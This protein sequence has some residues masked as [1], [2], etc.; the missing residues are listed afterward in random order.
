METQHSIQDGARV[1]G[2]RRALIVGLGISGMAAALRLR[3]IGWT[4]VIVERSAARRSGG[5]FIALFRAGLA[6]AG[7]LGILDRLTDLSTHGN[8]VDTDRV[9]RRWPGLS[10]DVFPGPP[11][12]MRRGDLEAAA[13]AALAADVEIRYGAEPVGIDQDAAGVDVTLADASSGDR[14]TERFD[15]VVG[16]DGLR[17]TV[18]RLVFG[19]DE[20]HLRRLGHM[21]LAY[22]LPAAL[23]GFSDRD[24]VLL[25]EPGRAMWSF[26][27]RGHPPTAL[28][29]YHTD[30][31]DAEFAGPIPDRVRQVFGPQP[32]GPVLGAA[33]DALESA[34][35]YVFDSVEQVHLDTWHRGRVVLVGDSAWCPTLY[36]GMGASSAMAGADLLGT[37]LNLCP[38]DVPVA[39]ARWEA[40]LR[41]SI[42]QVQTNGRAMQSL[43]VPASPAQLTRLRLMARLSKNPVTGPTL[44]RLRTRTPAF[45]LND[46]DFADPSQVRDVGPERPGR[47][48]PREP[49]GTPRPSL[50]RPVAVGEGRP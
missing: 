13:Y 18:R 48:D 47:T 5:Y 23:P 46:T 38:E 40:H 50:H 28:L 7:R 14:V 6:A 15:L 44:T 2:R 36:S 30:D 27:F 12:M 22:Q 4:P 41:P 19:P 32:T 45:R 39:L 37:M 20:N 29:T 8:G 26:P 49:N 3:Q 16:A 33:L 35:R 21:A 24:T 9:G 17:S 43:F 10:F 31:V 34:D 1:G 11:W 42:E 25:R